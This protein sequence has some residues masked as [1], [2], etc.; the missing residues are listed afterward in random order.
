MREIKRLVCLNVWKCLELFYWIINWLIM[1][2]SIIANINIFKFEYSLRN[3]RISRASLTL[4]LL[5][6]LSLIEPK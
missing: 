1:Y 3:E 4:F 5:E 2:V 6:S